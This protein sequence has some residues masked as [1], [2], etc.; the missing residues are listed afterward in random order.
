MT[1]PPDWPLGEPCPVCGSPDILKCE[2]RFAAIA[3]AKAAPEGR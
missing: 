3:S 1:H 2:Q